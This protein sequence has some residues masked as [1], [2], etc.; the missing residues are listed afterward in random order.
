MNV[1]LFRLRPL[2][3]A[4][5]GIHMELK[6]MNDMR[7]TELAYQGL[8]IK[9]PVADTS[10]PPPEVSYTDEEQDYFRELSEQLGKTEKYREPEE[11]EQ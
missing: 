1:G 7:E 5:Q 8:Y 2:I 10:G 4:V 9:P 3:K 11:S 6:R